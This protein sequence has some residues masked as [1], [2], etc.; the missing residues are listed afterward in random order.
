M[1]ISRQTFDPA[2]NYKSVRYH[3]DRDVLDSELNEMQSISGAE[4]RK[5]SETVLREGAILEGLAVVRSAN[6]LTIGPGVVAVEGFLESIPGGVLVYDSAKTEGIDFVYLELLKFEYGV[7]QDPTLI[8]PATGEPTAERE[9]WVVS[10]RER[11]TAA[12]PLPS[13]ATSRRLIPIYQF[14]RATGLVIA[15]VQEKS[16]IFIR[17]LRGTLNG[18]RID[19]HSITEEQLSFEAAEGL[20]SLLKN[21]AERTY[22]QAGSFLVRGFDSFVGTALDALNIQVITN[23]GRAYVQGYRFQKDLPTMTPVPASMSTKSVRG[24]QKTY[25]VGTRIYG[26]NSGPLKATTQVESIVAI[27]GNITRGSVGGGQDLL[28]PNPVV[29][30]LEVTQGAKTYVRGVDWQ[31]SGNYVDWTGTGQEPAIGTTYSVRWTYTRQMAK[32]VDYIDGGWFGAAGYPP[33][34]PYFY[35]V[36]AVNAAGETAFVPASPVRAVAV[37][38][39]FNIVRWTPVVGA[40]SYRVYRGIQNTGRTDFKLLKEVAGNASFFYFDDAADDIATANPPATSTTTLV[41]SPCSVTVEYTTLINFGKTSLGVEPVDGTNISID[42][43]YYVGR[44]D[45][46]YATRTEIKRLEG[47]PADFPKLPIVPEGTLALC[48]IDCPPATLAISVQNFRLTRVTMDQ[49]HEILQ[50]V[51]DLKYND[52]QFQMTTELQNR[53]AQTKKGIYSDDFSSDAQSDTFHPEWAARIDP[54]LQ[55]VA[56]PRATTSFSLEVDPASTTAQLEGSLALLPKVERTLVEQ[57]AWSEAKSLAGAATLP[58]SV[59]VVPNLGRRGRTQVVVS[60]SGFRPNLTSLT[61]RCDGIVVASNLSTGPYGRW[62]GAFVIPATAREGTRSVEVSDGERTAETDLL[63]NHPF[64]ITRIQRV[65][66]ER[67]ALKISA[68]TEKIA[69]RIVRVPVFRTL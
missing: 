49:I 35:T 55:F 67:S 40:T 21:I 44:K 43:D 9:K 31:Q 5:L 48:A 45:V 51:E 32:G 15:I 4:H 65:V 63:I 52:A 61:I 33:V 22:D 11:D 30:I 54:I 56:P 19:V 17:D 66:A 26:L 64:F 16:K 47:A 1:S 68:T 37:A 23:A 13:G 46:L 2:K 12:T 57:T 24:E 34:G 20:D 41:M 39:T 38:N 27:V 62:S 29:D 10:L 3:Q 6:V 53:T 18:R 42:Y 36:T 28:T 7:A 25:R 8:N 50:D 14:D 69:P 58:A 59:D 60:G